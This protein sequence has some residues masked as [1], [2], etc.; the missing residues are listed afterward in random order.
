M[1]VFTS[2]KNNRISEKTAVTVGKFDGFHR[3]HDLLAGKVASMKEE[4]YVSLVVTF[5]TS[6]RI[7][8]G[9]MEDGCLVTNEEKEILLE[10]MGI[11]ALAICPFGDEVMHMEP[12]EF[13]RIL[14]EQYSMKYLA[15][16]T[17]FRFGYRGRGDVDLLRK[18]S[19]E[20]D[21]CLDVYDKLQEDHRDISSTYIR[22]EIRKG[23]IEKANSLLG[24]EYFVYGTVVHGRHLGTRI[25]IPTINLIPPK[26][27]LLPPFGVYVTNVEIGG[28]IYHGVTNVGVKPTIEG[29]RQPGIE[30]H[31]M[32][33]RSNLYEQQVKVL[34]L[35]YLRP[36]KKFSSVQ[37]LKEQMEADK[38]AARLFFDAVNKN[39]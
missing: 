10:H 8:L 37:E 34:F 15:V 21:F 17:D 20:M 29:E 9:D 3:G 18:L 12:E 33:I 11:D 23:N 6:P 36:E 28:R 13:I 30:T 7:A 38:K 14:T 4:G 32:D 25:G 35:K 16:G 19:E 39:D 1:K 24:Y 2:L 31:I 5:D 22:E 26:E 27:K